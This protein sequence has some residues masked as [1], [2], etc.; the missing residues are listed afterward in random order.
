M[1][2]EELQQRLAAIAAELKGCQE[3]LARLEESGNLHSGCYKEEIL[4]FLTLENATNMDMRRFVDHISVNKN[5]TVRIILR[6][7]EETH[8]ANWCP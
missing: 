1:T 6:N 8:T 5:G 3:D 7:A 4:R 2:G